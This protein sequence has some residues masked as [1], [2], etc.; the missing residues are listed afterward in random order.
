M[1]Y[2][3]AAGM[4]MRTLRDRHAMIIVATLVAIA[5]I[6][7]PALADKSDR[8]G[9][10]LSSDPRKRVF[11]KFVAE[12][13]GPRIVVLGCLRDVD[14]FTVL[15]A[16]E[17]A[18]RSGQNLTLILANGS[19]RYAVEGKYEPNAIVV[20]QAGFASEIDADAKVL[21]QIRQKLLAVLEGNG[22]ITLTVGSSAR[23]LPLAGLGEA[24]R[25][26]KSVCFGQP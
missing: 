10:S 14:S 22:P 9:W 4:A 16:Q 8:K 12:N 3:S 24:L 13:G 7:L 21:R 15:S 19:A 6:I 5:G 18:A 20:G 23:E 17:I 2:L 1:Y 11:L 25:G 26:F